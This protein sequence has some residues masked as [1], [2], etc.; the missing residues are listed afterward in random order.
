MPREEG[1]EIL[2]LKPGYVGPSFGKKTGAAA[3]RSIAA[4]C[5]SGFLSARGSDN[6]IGQ[7]INPR[8]LTSG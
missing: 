6:L 7:I 4:H 1:G 8:N 3:N 5:Q 2:S